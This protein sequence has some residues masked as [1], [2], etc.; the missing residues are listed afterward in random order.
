MRLAEIGALRMAAALRENKPVYYF[1]DL[2]IAIALS[3]MHGAANDDPGLSAAIYL[4]PAVWK[5]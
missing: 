4:N 5:L 1:A 3:E 2:A